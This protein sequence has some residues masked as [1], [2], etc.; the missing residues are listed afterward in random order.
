MK[1]GF[2]LIELLVVVLIIGI[3][4]SVALPQYKKAVLKARGAEAVQTMSTLENALNLYLLEHPKASFSDKAFN[5]LSIQLPSC[6][7]SDSDA[8][9]TANFR[10]A[11]VGGCSKNI[12][13]LMASDNKGQ[14]P[15]LQSVR[16]NGRWNRTC[17]VQDMMGEQAKLCDS[18]FRPHGFS[19][20]YDPPAHL[21]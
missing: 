20:H 15:N 19:T 11:L 6:G 2:T 9:C 1:K 21:L 18:I 14:L 13:W 17:P 3:L 7:G 10:Y 8:F 4:S 5:E 12:C 16:M